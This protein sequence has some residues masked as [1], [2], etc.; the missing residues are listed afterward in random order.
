MVK[1]FFARVILTFNFLT[2]LFCLLYT[3]EN[4]SIKVIRI[5]KINNRPKID[6]FLND[7]CWKEINPVSGFFQYDPV[8]GIKASEETYVWVAYDEENIYFAFLMIDSEP[9]RI[10][11][12]ITPR[13]KFYGN[14]S[15]TVILDTYNDK[16]T[17]ISFSLNPKGI[18]AS[19][20]ETIWGGAARVSGNGWSAEMSIPFKSLRFPKKS[21]HVWGVNFKRYI[22]RLKET[23]YWT[24]VGRDEPLLLK[25]GIIEGLEGIKPGYNIEF[26]PYTGYRYSQWEEEK[27]RKFASGID[28]KY[29]ISSNLTFDLTISPDYSEVESDPFIY[30]LSPYEI[31]LDEYRPFFSEASQYF[32]TYF[33]LF[34]SRRVETPKLALKLTGKT[35]GISIGILGADIKTA[36][37]DAYFSIFRLKKDVLENSE[38]GIYFTG[39]HH[40]YSWNRNIGIDFNFQFENIYFLR[41]QMVLSYVKGIKN[42]DI[43]MYNLNVERFKDSGLN[44]SLNFER[45]GKDVHVETGYIPQKNYQDLTGNIGY[46]WRFNKGIL[47][48]LRLYFGGYYGEDCVKSKTGT[49]AY[50]SSLIEFANQSRLFAGIYTGKSKAQ[51]FKDQELVWSDIYFLNKGLELKYIFSAGRVLKRYGFG[52]SISRIPIYKE[53]FTRLE[54]GIEKKLEGYIGIRPLSFLELSFTTEFIEQKSLKDNKK[55]FIGTSYE[56]SLHYQITKY[57][58]FNTRIKGESKYDQ[59]NLDLLLGYYFGAGN[60]IQLIYKRGSKGVHEFKEG[61]YSIAL[62]ASYLLRI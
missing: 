14:D 30:Q 29:G 35:K 39:F 22:H 11:G 43:G 47:K 55:N 50:F 54:D 44:F 26:F 40:K 6:G 31:K 8:N 34:Y 4:E 17:S 53:G 1:I 21:S 5:K 15:I 28:F 2:L 27:D 59:Y 46:S 42:K 61:G 62:K 10:Y 12:E 7:S 16:R 32:E 18:Q 19:S 25:S 13:N 3:Q 9:E 36:N 45:V 51:L 20:I 57:L 33:N 37:A 60:I 48:F 56:T 24:K 23:D 41:G 52:I 49:Q 38:I 58:F